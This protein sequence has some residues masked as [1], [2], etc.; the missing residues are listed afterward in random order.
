ML[1]CFV[2][3]NAAGFD[4]LLIVG[5]DSPALT[6]STIA[7]WTGLLARSR[8]VVGPAEDGGYY[9]IGCHV[10]HPR[11]FEGVEWSGPRTLAQTVVALERCD[12]PVAYLPPHYDVD[13]PAD[14]SRLA[15]DPNLGPRSRQWLESD[16]IKT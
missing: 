13:T 1:R 6:A 16:G 3:M 4:P 2:E 12:M 5:S 9:A 10:P 11:M 15:L 8:S 7:P 14:L